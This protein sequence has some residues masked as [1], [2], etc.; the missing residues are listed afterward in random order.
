MALGV[1]GYMQ[2][3]N[4]TGGLILNMSFSVN[5]QYVAISR[6]WTILN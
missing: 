2:Q 3:Q 5:A 6:A 1:Q 4:R